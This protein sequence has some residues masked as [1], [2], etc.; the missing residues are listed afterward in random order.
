MSGRYVL[1]TP[2]AND[3]DEIV[4]YVLERDGPQRA[5][6]VA[7][8]FHEVFERLASNPRLGH[9]REDLTPFPVLFFGVWS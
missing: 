2:A 5:E 3:L 1:S 4:T 6:H 7:E 8:R 9:R